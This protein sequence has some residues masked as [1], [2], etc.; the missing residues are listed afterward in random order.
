M[1]CL[2]ALNEA[3]IVAGFLRP[4]LTVHDPAAARSRRTA[5]IARRDGSG[6]LSFFNGAGAAKI[7]R[8][9]QRCHATIRPA[10][11]AKAQAPAYQ[12]RQ[13]RPGGHAK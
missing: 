2:P 4:R 9:R 13:G 1:A 7:Q 3:R 6:T 11:H 12:L 8:R 10:H 5:T